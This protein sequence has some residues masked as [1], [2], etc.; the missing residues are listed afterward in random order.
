M[1]QTTLDIYITEI[2]NLSCEYCYVDL[3]KTE[4]NGIKTESFMQRVDLLAYKTI[5]F[6]GWEPLL[7]YREMASIIDAV[8]KKDAS[9]HFSVITNGLLLSGEKLAFFKEHEVTIAISVHIPAMNRVLHIKMLELYIKY[10]HI[11]T[12]NL[13]FREH[14]ESVTTKIFLLLAKAW[15]T[16]FSLAPVSNDTWASIE[17]LKHELDSIT[18]YIMTHSLININELDWREIK[19]LHADGFCTKE[20]V[21][22][23]GN[24]KICTRFDKVEFLS[25]ESNI[26][27]IDT[28]FNTINQCSSCKVRW[29]CVC[30]KGWYLDNF[31]DS[32]EY[33]PDKIRLFHNINELFIN[34]YKKLA[35]IRNKL[36]FLTTHI[37]EIRLNLTEQCNLRCDYCYLDFKNKRMQSS[38]WRNII[39]FFIEQD[40]DTKIISFLWGEPLLE[41]D[42]LRDFVVYAREKWL[43]F[44]KK[45][46][47]KIATNGILLT[48]EIAAFLLKY[49]FE[50]HISFNGTKVIQDATRDGSYDRAIAKIG[51]LHDI[52]YPNELITILVVLFPDSSSS[53]REN[54]LSM[55]SVLDFSRIYL[56]MYIWKKY[57]W[58][59]W[60]YALLEKWLA[61]IYPIHRWDSAIEIVN[62]SQ[63]IESRFLDIST[64]GHIS[65]NSLWFFHHE[66]IDFSPKKYLDIVCL[67]IKN[68]YGK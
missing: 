53:L 16:N 15:F 22:L 28:A 35:W 36:N 30:N 23:I 33:D 65:D 67:K 63:T 24:K 6:Y 51:I 21:D 4:K 5:K 9:I 8:H 57:I 44:S 3:K 60:Q 34:F 45:I 27:H 39:D 68:S 20:Q 31:W 43:L 11:I 38:I 2:C 17:W 25:H 56:E 14:H 49:E 32:S 54:L 52:G 58:S 12:F 64:S 62:F 26:T 40:W 59:K 47:F 10:S 48:D 46:T 42:L 55:V 66:K 13:L 29:F 1:Q 7:K 61:D 41:F 37:T 19:N 50:T 18:A